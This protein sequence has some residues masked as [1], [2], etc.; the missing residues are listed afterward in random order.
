MT[1][2]HIS[3]RWFHLGQT[4]PALVFA[5]FIGFISAQANYAPDNNFQ[6]VWQ[7]STPEPESGADTSDYDVDGLPAWFEL[8]LGTAP[9][10]YDTDYD[11]IND[12]DEL[13]T[14]QTNP[15]NWDTDGNGQSDLTDF[16][17]ANPPTENPGT[18]ETEANTSTE[19]TPPVDS[20]GDGLSDDFEI[21]SSL[22]DIATADTDGNGRSDY[23]DY[24]YP[25]S[26]PDSDS[27]GV[28]DTVETTEGTDPYSVDSDGDGL[29]DGEETNVFYTD[30][31]N[32]YSR[33]I[34]YSDWYMVDLT[35]SDAGGV[36]DRI[37][38]YLGMNPS[39]AND[40]VNGDLDGDGITNAESYND[41]TDPAANV[42]ETYDRDSDGMTDVWEVANSLNPDDASDASGDPD[43]DS[44][45]NVAEFQRGT[46][47]QVADNSEDTTSQPVDQTSDGSTEITDTTSATNTSTTTDE[48]L[49]EGLTTASNACYGIAGAFAVLAAGTAALGLL[50]AT[51]LFGTIA[52]GFGILGAAFG[53]AANQVANEPDPLP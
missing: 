9:V 2:R 37:E 36:P 20:D 23:D 30:P 24:Y 31:N 10:L 16:Y 32:A 4:L 8:W 38:S 42:T 6:P 14:T 27:D 26:N 41:G 40:D 25:V 43:S 50:P 48:E 19:E 12:G 28:T 22:T 18:T 52:G 35:D 13:A 45:N 47:P 44:Y 29:T 3:R 21:N 34:Q 11:G 17:A 51:L 7:S 39:D 53:E 46:D 1:L 33:S 15:L 5:S 49:V